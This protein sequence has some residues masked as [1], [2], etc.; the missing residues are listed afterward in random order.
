M[1]LII[2]VYNTK[3]D[4]IVVV[5]SSQTTIFSFTLVQKKLGLDY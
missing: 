5:S 1:Y 2:G 4:P 3:T